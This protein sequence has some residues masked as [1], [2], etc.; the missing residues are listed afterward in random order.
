[1]TRCTNCDGI[2]GRTDR[3]CF[4][5]GDRVDGRSSPMSFGKILVLA[6]MLLIVASAG[7][8]AYL[9]YLG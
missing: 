3:V 5:C 2:I 6:L 1:M 9:V 4:T 8:T 7:I